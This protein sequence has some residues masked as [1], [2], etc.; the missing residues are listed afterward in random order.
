M[1]LTVSKMFCS[2]PRCCHPDSPLSLRPSCSTVITSVF[3][4]AFFVA[5]ENG[6]RTPYFSEALSR[7]ASLRPN[8]KGASIA[9]IKRPPTSTPQVTIRPAANKAFPSNSSHLQ[10]TEAELPTLYRT[11]PPAVNRFDYPWR[12]P[13]RLRLPTLQQSNYRVLYS[14]LRSVSGE[15]LGHAMATVNAD[16]STAIRLRLTYT[17]RI[18]SFASLTRQ[19]SGVNESDFYEGADD[20]SKYQHGG[21]IE[22][23]FGWGVGEIPR[24]RIQHSICPDNKMATS[25]YDCLVCTQHDLAKRKQ[26]LKSIQTHLPHRHPFAQAPLNFNQIVEIPTNLSYFYP[27]PP[28]QQAQHNVKTFLQSHSKPYTVFYMPKAY[29]DRSP[30]Y[31]VFGAPQRSFFFHKYWD[32]H[33][34]K[35]D[36][37]TV[38]PNSKR[39]TQNQRYKNFNDYRLHSSEGGLILP[40]LSRAPLAKLKQHQIQ[41]AIHARRGDFFQAGRPM[42]STLSFARMVRILVSQVIRY[43]RDDIFSRMPISVAFYSE[44]QSRKGHIAVR[45][46]DTSTMNDEYIDA[47]RTVQNETTV[48]KMLRN[49]SIDNLGNVFGTTGLSV[50]LRVSQNTVLSVHEMV[51]A[52]IFIGSQSGL[53]THVVGSMCR[54]AVV[55]L[56]CCNRNRMS[57][58]IPFNNVKDTD[59][60]HLINVE[61]IKAMRVLWN[62][63]SKANSASATRAVHEQ[64]G[65]KK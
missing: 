29:C 19:P 45:G 40:L 32:A 23:L 63:F 26:Q 54:A 42:V 14:P 3:F 10:S 25:P 4:F 17:H 28:T 60:S 43:R 2:V 22:E 31:S 49:N 44:G 41:I 12:L 11:V 34:Y 6:A 18:A 65:S 50:S 21:A 46:H 5:L 36:K 27:Y 9:K 37:Y 8:S 62:A 39:A 30:A 7:Q 33:G 24:E 15:G 13:A 53:S 64:R 20:I 55:L 59:G 35:K 61:Y 38:Q 51:A 56:P 48:E 47:D 58:F 1:A 52:D 16:L 57:N